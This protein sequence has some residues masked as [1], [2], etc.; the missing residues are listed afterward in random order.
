MMRMRARAY[1]FPDQARTLKALDG[2]EGLCREYCITR[3]QAL[4]ALDPIRP[5][6]FPHDSNALTMLAAS[7]PTSA[8]RTTGFNRHC[9][10]PSHCPSGGALRGDGRL[11][12]PAAG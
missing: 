1:H 12:L 7:V 8:S 11:T 3:R 2:L 9:W 6:W 4:A 5:R 10:P